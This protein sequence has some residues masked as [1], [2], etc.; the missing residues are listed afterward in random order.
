[1]EQNTLL[2]ITHNRLTLLVLL[3]Q[4]VLPPRAW[5]LSEQVLERLPS[6]LLD[7]TDSTWSWIQPRQLD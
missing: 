2:N 6:Y 7:Q 3:M 4:Q 1:M 5:S